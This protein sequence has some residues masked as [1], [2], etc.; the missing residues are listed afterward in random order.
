MMA[1]KFLLII[2]I[3]ILPNNAQVSFKDLGAIGVF[4]IKELDYRV[5]GDYSTQFLIVQLVPN[6]THTSNCTLTPLTAYKNTISKLLAPINETLALTSSQMLPYYGNKRF[7][8]EIMAGAALTVAT[9]AQITAGIALYEAR[10][11]AAQIEAIKESLKH[12]NA[13]IQSLQTAQKETVVAI[14]GLQEQINTHIIPQINHITCELASQQL[15]VRLLE[16]YTEM[17]TIF[18]P[19]FQAP[20]SGEVTIQALSRA[21]NGNLTGLLAELGYSGTD[22]HNIL[23]INGIKG[24]VI[25]VDPSLGTLIFVIKYPTFIKVPDATIVQLAYISYHSGPYD[26]LTQGPDFLMVRGYT[27]AD[28]DPTLCT[29][30]PSYMMCPRDTTRPFSMSMTSCLRGNITQC[31][32][33][34]VTDRDAPRFLI[35]KGNLVVNCITVNCKCESPEHNIIQPPDIPIMILDNS[36]C[37]VHFIDGIRVALGKKQLQ[38]VKVDANIE[39]G[40]VVIVDPLDVSHQ[41]SLV[42]KSISKSEQHLQIAMDKLN[43]LPTLT[44]SSSSVTIAII[45]SI[46]SIVIV[47]I[48]I[49]ILYRYMNHLTNLRTNLETIEKGPTLAPKQSAYTNAYINQGFSYNPTAPQIGI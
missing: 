48:M 15:R 4:P 49:I 37:S 10:Q 39:L 3:I 42:E 5:T 46:I 31:P 6:I 41:L 11:N 21:A 32:R 14:Q 26:W 40:P 23:E 22:L 43:R 8:A 45:L 27:I 24:T 18:G 33:V 38:S 36:T 29:I 25:D 7:V 34:L 30:G 20:L 12:T 16:Y 1:Y 13:A 44:G 47:I 9:S 35:L 19:I 2:I 28:I 17:L